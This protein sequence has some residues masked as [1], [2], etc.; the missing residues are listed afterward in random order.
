L[1]KPSVQVEDD[2]EEMRNEGTSSR[3]RTSNDSVSDNAEQESSTSFLLIAI[4]M[5]LSQQLT[6]INGTSLHLIVRNMKPA[7]T[8][9]K[10]KH[11][12]ATS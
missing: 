11:P 2:L 8:F 12:Y 6:G 7:V 4:V 5:Q 3:A 1:E 10:R 9:D